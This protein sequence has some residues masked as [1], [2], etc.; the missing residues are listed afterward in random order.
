MT[1]RPAAFRAEFVNL[2]NV[3]SRKVVQLVFEIPV[4]KTDEALNCLGWPDAASPKVCAIAVLN[5][6]AAQGI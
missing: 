2:R 1:E 3:Q 4:E 5:E 6:D